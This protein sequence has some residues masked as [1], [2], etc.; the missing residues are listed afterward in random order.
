MSEFQE[1]IER[2]QLGPERRS[3]ILTDEEKEITAYHEAGHALVSHMLPHGYALRKI[4][5][6]PRG[7]AGGVT[8][9]LEDD[10]MFF[11]RSKFKA[12]IATALGGRVA[13]EIIYGE[14]TTGASNDLQQVTKI[15]RS[16]VTQ[17]GMSD[18]MGLRVYGDRQEMVFLGR[19]ISEQRD[20]SDAVA[21]QI[22]THVR[23]II[24]EQYKRVTEILET[25]REQLELVA[26]TLLE[27]ETL[28]AA[29]FA[30]LLEGRE[31]PSKTSNEP[32]KPEPTVTKKDA[33]AGWKK[34][35][36]LDLPPSPSPA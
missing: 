2:V 10:A 8:W 7:M 23:D 35:P 31:L 22:D 6:I 12:L 19:E 16:M 20:Y 4:T 32:A 11:S 21:E 27:V 36:A 3:R 15:A 1:A 24:D 17:Y 25:N 29:E 30:A 33:E 34:P 28:E 9:F 5:I 18:E 26:K 14:I 13:E